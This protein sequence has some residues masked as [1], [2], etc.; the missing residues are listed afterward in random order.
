VKKGMREAAFNS[1]I[2]LH[3]LKPSVFSKV[4]K[5]E[6]LEKR[7]VNNPIKVW[8]VALHA[9]ARTRKAQKLRAQRAKG[10]Q[11]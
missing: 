5:E 1:R 4:G 3:G 2:K 7:R 11:I 8:V 10:R 6:Y 9:K